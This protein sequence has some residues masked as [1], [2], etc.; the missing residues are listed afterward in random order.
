MYL[1]DT[2]SNLRLDD[3]T[4]WMEHFTHWPKELP[5]V[6]HAEGRIFCLHSY[7]NTQPYRLFH[8][9]ARTMA[10]ALMVATLHDRPLHIAHVCLKEELAVIRA[11]KEKGIRVTCEVCP[12][13]LFLDKDFGCSEQNQLTESRKEVKFSSIGSCCS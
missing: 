2:F 8:T 6:V 12:H 9:S 13:H 7:H 1:N 5:I 4:T 11:A 3:M 10:A